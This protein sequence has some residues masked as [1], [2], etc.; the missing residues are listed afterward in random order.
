MLRTIA[1]ITTCER[2]PKS[3]FAEFARGR[4]ENEMQEA[5]QSGAI[6]KEDI[7]K[8][9]EEE[10][11]ENYI[12]LRKEKLEGE[13]RALLAL[14]KIFEEQSLEVDEELV[15]AQTDSLLERAQ[16]AGQENAQVR[17][18]AVSPACVMASTHALFARFRPCRAAGGGPFTRAGLCHGG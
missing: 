7:H 2:L 9:A 12:E 16:K 11:V 3:A 18:P 13:F 6:A 1:S 8:Y 17:F 5:I 15:K 10:F 4:Y 14:D